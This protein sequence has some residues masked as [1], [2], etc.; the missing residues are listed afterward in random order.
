[1]SYTIG[2]LVIDRDALK[3][4]SAA[5]QAIVRDVLSGLYKRL[6]A[7][8]RIDNTKAEQALKANGLQFVTANVNEVPEWR[9]AVASAMD[10]MAA[11]GAFSADLLTEVRRHLQDYRKGQPVPGVSGARP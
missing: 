6:D 7:Q 1:M 3:A 4:V 10:G 11:K 5:D 2:V 8:N 9:A